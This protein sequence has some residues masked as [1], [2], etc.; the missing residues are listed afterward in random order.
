MPRL[1][2]KRLPLLVVLGLLVLSVAVP[3]AG[4]ELGFGG[5]SAPS[6]SPTAPA[7]SEA[8]RASPSPAPTVAAT[9]SPTAT[10]VPTPGTVEAAIVPVTH[11]RATFTNTGRKEV[12]DVLA[13]TSKRYEALEL[14]ADDADAI[15]A[16]VGAAR[17]TV[18]ARLVL[19]KDAATL[20]RDLAKNRKR[21]AFLRAED[22]T[23]AVRALAWG[24][25]ALFG[26]DRVKTADAW[27]LRAALLPREGSEAFDPAATWTLFAGGDILLDR[28]VYQTV[29]IRG[30]GVDFPF[31]GGTA[32]I[33]SRCKDCSPLGW[34]LPRTRRTG[35]AGAMRE[36][37]S[38]ADD[39]DRQLREPRAEPLPVA[40]AEH[41]L[42]RRP[43]PDRRAGQ[44]RHRL[45]VDR[46]QPHRRR[47]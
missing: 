27:R 33:T 38:G 7:A 46:Q 19:A 47:R 21:L 37:I 4:S 13:G 30:K 15:L 34:D 1:P 25:A 42:H 36:L 31:D 20:R 22:V 5:G 12:A 2:T 40:Y 29:R 45:R 24:Q 6:T 26:V 39:R 11:F 35:N 16:A 8:V 3:M 18:A 43:Q 44:C 28:G 14:V 9:A 32:E 10:P 23:P 41:G 17:P